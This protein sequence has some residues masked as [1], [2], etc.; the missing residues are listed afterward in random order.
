MPYWKLTYQVRT[1]DYRGGGVDGPYDTWTQ[2]KTKNA[3]QKAA[4]TYYAQNVGNATYLEIL[5]CVNSSRA[6][7][8]DAQAP[9]G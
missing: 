1:P 9:S 8:L 2:A 7:M 4:F 3:A 5:S 6:E